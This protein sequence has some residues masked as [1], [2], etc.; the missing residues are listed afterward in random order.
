MFAHTLFVK[1]EPPAVAGASAESRELTLSVLRFIKSNLEPIRAMGVNVRVQKVRDEDLS[2][3]QAVEMMR[4]RGISRLPALCT[5]QQVYTGAKA[6]IGLYEKNLSIFSEKKRRPPPKAAA[7]TP[8]VE[9][10][11]H[12]EMRDGESDDEGMSEGGNS[13]MDTYRQVISRREGSG[14]AAGPPRLHAPQRVQKDEDDDDR[15]MPGR[16]MGQPA[17][18]PTGNPAM[19]PNNVAS[20]RG[21]APPPSRPQPPMS[22]PQPPQPSR[23]PTASPGGAPGGLDDDDENSPQDDLMERAY[24]ANMDDSLAHDD[25]GRNISD[26]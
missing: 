24:L 21:R 4:E 23:M 8:D 11:M 1:V 9:S 14:G 12:Q 18:R 7:K 16:S 26:E 2:N 3:E 5:P 6:I 19:R 20:S 25:E 13:M 17:G 10:Y 22:R 15:P